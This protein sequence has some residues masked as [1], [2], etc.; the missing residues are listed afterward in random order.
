MA[1]QYRGA[2]HDADVINDLPERRESKGEE[3]AIF[4]PA[5][6]GTTSGHKQ[7]QVLGVPQ[8]EPCLAANRAYHA[9]YRARRRAGTIH[10]GFNPSKCGTYAGYSRHRR[11]TVAPCDPCLEAFADYMK[12]FRAQRKAA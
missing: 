10:K 5:K 1:Y 8:C 2:I 6:C 3:P 9:E 7:H 4:D 12:T 11:S